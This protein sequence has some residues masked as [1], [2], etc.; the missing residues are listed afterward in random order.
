MVVRLKG[1]DPFVFGRGGEEALRCARRASPLR[2]CPGHRR[3]RRHRLRRHPRHPP[4]ARQRGSAHD[5]AREDAGRGGGRR[6]RRSTG[7]RSRPSPERSSSTWAYASCPHIAASL[8]DAGRP[9][10]EPG[11]VVERG[12]LPNQ[13]TVTGT[14]AHVAG[15]ARRR[16]VRS[17]SITVVGR[18]RGARRAVGVAGGAAAERAHGGGDTGARPN[19]WAGPAASR[20]GG[21][22]VQAPAIRIQPLED[23]GLQRR[24]TSPRTTLICLTSPNGVGPLFERLAKSTAPRRRARAGGCA[25]GRD[26]PRHR[27]GAGR[28]RRP[29][30]IVPARFVAESLVDALAELPIRR[31]LV[32]RAA[33]PATCCPTR[34]ARG[35]PRWTCWSC[36]KRSPS[37]SPRRPSRRRARPTTS[38]SPPPPPCAS[39]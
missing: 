38:P 19:K 5:R 14:L 31:A 2:S 18:R 37:R 7:R 16:E 26:R 33:R 22:V 39:S 21:R 9:A 24:S 10:S 30:D 34:C 13:R 35:A 25:R 36:T 3:R 12:T 15:G 8:I 29:A 1:G 27:A 23:G 32:A 20:A 28:A 6:G 17:P 11:G 4:R